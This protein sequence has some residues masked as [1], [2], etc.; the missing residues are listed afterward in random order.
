[1][2]VKTIYGGVAIATVIS[3]AAQSTYAAPTKKE[4]KRPNIIFILSD[5]AGYAD[6]GFQGSKQFQTPNL[7]KM[8]SQG[9][10]LEQ[11]YTTDAVSGPSRA[12]LM[13]GRYQQ[14]FG[15]EENNV[16]NL[17]SEN[18]LYKWEDMGV[19]LDEK[20][21][22][23]YLKQ[24]GYK[25][26]IFGKWHLG[27]NDEY[28]PFKRGFDHFVGFRSGARDYYEIENKAKI[29]GHGEEKKLEYGFREFKEPDRYLTDLLA[30][31]ACDYIKENKENPFFIYLAFNAVHTPLQAD[32]ADMEQFKHIS[33]KKRQV[34][35]A[36]TLSL[37]RNCGKVWE[38][39]KKEGLDK[40]TIIVFGNDNGGPNGAETSNYPLR[41]MKGTFLEGG[42]RVPSFII[43]PKV[44]DKGTRYPYP[45]S[46]FDYLPTFANLAGVDVPEDAALDGVD[47][48]PYVSGKRGDERPHQTLYWKCENRGTVRDG[49]YKFMRFPDRP[50]EL[51]D[52]SKDETEKNNIAAEHPEL[53]EKYYKM[54][55]NWEMTLERPK[56]MLER[57]CEQRVMEQFYEQEEYKNPIEQK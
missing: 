40:N 23:Y 45:I 30:D 7:D 12:G 15:I 19:D 37:D 31:E 5:D 16:P 32:K 36:M 18:G 41:G 27:A 3:L 38:T 4:T 53:I 17:M 51:Y 21:I 24:A 8:A 28:H 35:G 49:D 55:F 2:T 42:I 47:I 54:L 50:A 39:L 11:A 22:P 13:T 52:I 25:C 26:A 46:F 20:M 44:I 6:F 57:F 14:R 9:V 56:W 10:I 48:L 34:L 1:M 33:S 29:S 43:Y